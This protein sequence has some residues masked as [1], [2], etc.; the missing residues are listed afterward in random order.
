MREQ[1]GLC[2]FVCKHVYQ[3]VSICLPI[4][5][6][7]KFFFLCALLCV[8]VHVCWCKAASSLP[9]SGHRVQPT[10]LI[11]AW[12]RERSPFSLTLV[13]LTLKFLLKRHFLNECSTKI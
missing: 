11:P 10:R 1:A 7:V 12:T 8:F 2:E 9:L 6:A 13:S 5:P 4:Y 3:F